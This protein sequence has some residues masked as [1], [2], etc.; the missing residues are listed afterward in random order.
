MGRGRPK[1][2]TG[3]R[4]R[5]WLLAACAALAL[6]LF[7]F[8]QPGQKQI[9]VYAP[10]SSYSL[11]VVDR[12]GNEY[13]GLAELLEPL[14][15]ISA[16]ADGKRW[17]L[18]FGRAAEAQFTA[19]KTKGKASK[20]D[21]ELVT[22]FVLENGRGM[23]PL[24]SLAALLA[25][26]IPEHSIQFHAPSRRLFLDKTELRYSAEIRKDKGQ[27]VLTFSA[28]VN[29]VIGTEQ[30]KLR[31]TFRREP[32]VASSAGE[33]QALNDKTMSSLAF[34]EANGTAELT[35]NAG[36]PLTAAFSN[37]R[38]TITISPVMAPAPP[39]PV[40]AQAPA[41]PARPAV[42][43]APAKPA[44]PAPK[45]L[46]IL[47]AAH[48]GDDRGAAITPKLN[49]KDVTMVMARRLQKELEAKGIATRLLRDGDVALTTDQRAV[50]TN[51][52]NTSLFIS[53]H[54]SGSGS[55]VRVY[56]SPLQPERRTTAFLPWKTAQ[57]AFVSAS[58]EVATGIATELLKHDIP[59]SPM[60]VSVSPLDSVAAPGLAIEFA[61]PAGGKVDDIS[62]QTYQRAICTAIAAAVAGGRAYLPHG[63]A[64]R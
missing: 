7:A 57:A 16:K 53:L 61:P 52:A 26:L 2:T 21:V 47:D 48:G 9:T 18:R 36:A 27:L 12:E 8:A 14:G 28:P 58:N 31:M 1:R 46:V 34:S 43:P 15:N 32:L 38:K 11:P 60:R 29:P 40:T 56:T 10:Q 44:P 63:E 3:S 39:P 59:A 20:H 49:E 4:L 25:A 5:D 45:F 35:V 62:S 23:V 64:G 13:V 24:R 42:N 6:G 19:G 50:I 37:D 33:N 51:A 55:G 22:P 17:K 54:A 30:G 41:Q